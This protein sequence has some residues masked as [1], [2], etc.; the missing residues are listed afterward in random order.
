MCP[1]LML[2]QTNLQLKG[3]RKEGRVTKK[4]KQNLDFINILNILRAAPSSTADSEH[5]TSAGDFVN[6]YFPGPEGG[7]DDWKLIE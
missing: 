3:S 4:N 6:A 2:F 5:G 1:K 7:Q